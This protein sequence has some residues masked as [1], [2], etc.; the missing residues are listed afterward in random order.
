MNYV[1]GT[2]LGNIVYILHIMH[3]SLTCDHCVLCMWFK[4]TAILPICTPLWHLITVCGS[5][6][7]LPFSH[8]RT[9]WHVTLYEVCASCICRIAL[10]LPPLGK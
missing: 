3:H 4:A 8:M 5:K 1:L 6:R 10:H 9:T 7:H 2:C